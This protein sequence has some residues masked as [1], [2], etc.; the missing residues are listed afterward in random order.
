[1]VT[2]VHRYEFGICQYFWSN[3]GIKLAF[4]RKD[5][6]M[7]TDYPL[8]NTSSRVGYTDI[9]KYP[10][11]G[12]KSHHVLLGVYDFNNDKTIYLDTGEPKEQ[13]LT[14]I[15]WGPQEKYIY[16]AVLNRDQN[17]L[18]LNKYSAV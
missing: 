14:N 11:A 7:V 15:C 2:A 12:M 6:S 8:M 13:Y 17:H 1:M 10:M 9:I 5:E 16:V 3:D 18:K 4:Y